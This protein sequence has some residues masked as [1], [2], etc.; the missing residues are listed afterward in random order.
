MRANETMRTSLR[1]TDDPEALAR[2]VVETERTGVP[3]S[4]KRVEI[5]CWILSPRKRKSVAYA[6]RWHGD[7][8][9]LDPL[10]RPARAGRRKRHYGALA[11]GVTAKHRWW[12]ASLKLGRIDE[13][14]TALV[15]LRMVRWER[16][17]Q[18]EETT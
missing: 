12:T 17:A 2:F 18:E 3:L 15:R 1:A 10:Y 5:L 8:W 9:W 14:A 6:F 4:P 11:P 16:V 7:G 13:V